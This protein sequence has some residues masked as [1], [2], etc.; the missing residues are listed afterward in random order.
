MPAE[1]E[2]QNALRAAGGLPP[3]P[4]LNAVTHQQPAAAGD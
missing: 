1:L 2:A 4:D 3:L